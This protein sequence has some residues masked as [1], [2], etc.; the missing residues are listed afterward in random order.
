MH[1]HLL[2]NCKAKSYCTIS[3][4]T[5]Y[6]VTKNL[7]PIWFHD[8]T[9]GVNPLP[10]SKSCPSF[11][12]P[13]LNLET[14]LLKH[15]KFLASHDWNYACDKICKHFE[16]RKQVHDICVFTVAG[17][18]LLRVTCCSL[19]CESRLCCHP[20]SPPLPPQ[21]CRSATKESYELLLSGWSIFEWFGAP[22]RRRVHSFRVHFPPWQ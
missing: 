10:K 20:A 3:L 7:A 16:S 1:P 9:K 8:A 11:H 21:K 4:P 2:N 6:R 18:D 19:F 22:Y 15:V 5:F 13:S 14:F 17:T 12:A